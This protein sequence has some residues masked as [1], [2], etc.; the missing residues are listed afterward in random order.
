MSVDTTLRGFLFPP[1]TSIQ[2]VRW[3]TPPPGFVKL[4]FD[5]LLINPSATDEFIPQNWFDKL[6]KVGTIY[7]DTTTIPVAEDRALRDGLSA[8]IQARYHNL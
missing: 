7:Y 6:L 2:Y 3:H 1:S 5:E 8:A 4:N